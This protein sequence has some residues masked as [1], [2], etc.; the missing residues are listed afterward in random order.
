MLAN[1]AVIEARDRAEAEE[2]LR[3]RQEGTHKALEEASARARGLLEQ[4][5]EKPG[6]VLSES[7]TSQPGSSVAST[8]GLLEASSKPK[9]LPPKFLTPATPRNPK[10]SSNFTSPVLD[11]VSG[12]ES[13]R[14]KAQANGSQSLG[15]TDRSSTP[16]PPMPS[17]L[18]SE[19]ESWTPVARRRG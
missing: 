18:P 13:S 5:T 15:Q 11:G 8:S 9:V 6:P 10:G 17:R 4:P 3:I 7:T 19:T 14:E 12:Q 16:P 1:V 2:R